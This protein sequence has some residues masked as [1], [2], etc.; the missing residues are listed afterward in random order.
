MGGKGSGRSTWKLTSEDYTKL[1]T[2]LFTG[3]YKT[4]S[5]VARVFGVSREYVRQVNEKLGLV[6]RRVVIADRIE[7][8]KLQ[9][10]IK[11]QSCIERLKEA[12]PV[13]WAAYSN[14]KQRCNNP[15]NPGYKHYGGRGI[16][17]LFNNFRDFW[18]HIGPRPEGLSLDRKDNDGNYEVGNVKWATQKEQC[19]PGKRRMRIT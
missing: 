7:A 18:E 4:H 10:K 19:A 11:I 5:E 6:T 1:A 12:Y 2:S 13:E 14:A 17:F 15:K 16:L 8:A 3:Q 9:R